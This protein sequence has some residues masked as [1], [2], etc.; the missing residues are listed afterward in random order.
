MPKPAKEATAPP[1]QAQSMRSAALAAVGEKA[2]AETWKAAAAS[3]PKAAAVQV[4]RAFADLRCACAVQCWVAQA[5]AVAEMCSLPALHVIS[6]AT[7]CSSQIQ[8]AFAYHCTALHF[9]ATAERAV[10]TR[11]DLVMHRNTKARWQ[12]SACSLGCQGS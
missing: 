11:V 9:W 4:A 3:P 8:S 2:G 1:A 5:Q 7:D 12:A 10:V 6:A